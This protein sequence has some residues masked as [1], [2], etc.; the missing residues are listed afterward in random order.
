MAA[1]FDTLSPTI[2]IRANLTPTWA[3]QIGTT[4][5]S[6]ALLANHYLAEL[7]VILYLITLI[8]STLKANQPFGQ[9]ELT[10]DF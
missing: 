10:S 5:F 1:L 9:V 4:F 8:Y 3:S 6:F 7:Y 2:S